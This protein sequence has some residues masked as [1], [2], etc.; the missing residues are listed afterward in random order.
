MA[1][2][3][4]TFAGIHN[5]NEFYSQRYL[6]EIFTGDIRG[7]I[8]R[9]RDGAEAAG[10]PSAGARTP[11]EALRAL[12]RDYLQF[13]RQFAHERQHA[14]RV[15][16]QHRWFGQLLGAL[17]YESAPHNHILDDGNE[18]PVLFAGR[19][20]GSVSLL[21]LGDY[22]PLFVR[23]KLSAIRIAE[24]RDDAFERHPGLREAWVTQLE[25]A[26]ATR[27]FLN[28]R[29]NYP[30][31]EGQKTNLYKCLLPQ[32][33]S[34]GSDGGVAGFLHPEG[35]Y[36]DPK[37]GAFREPLYPRLRAHFHFRN[38]KRLFAEV[39][40]EAL[41]SINVYGRPSTSPAFATLFLSCLTRPYAELWQELCCT[42]L[43]ANFNTHP[44]C[45][46]DGS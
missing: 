23:R 46:E 21:V 9:W 30:F 20:H 38:E 36:D 34:I 3:A 44:N 6:S 15:E 13:R 24:L 16:R 45:S 33:W 7:T 11:N 8:A 43:P 26:E 5:E 4:A 31:L 37:G 25:E 41:F 35:V 29:Q 12:A 19:Q 28:A 1:D 10:G 2:T 39:H 17:G 32:A 18:V 27:T 14:T 42:N 40:H 22:N